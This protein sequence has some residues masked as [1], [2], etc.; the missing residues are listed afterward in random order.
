M[1]Q[2]GSPPSAAAATST[3]GHRILQTS[4]GQQIIVVNQPNAQSNAQVHI[5]AIT[6]SRG[7]SYKM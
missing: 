7:L 3:G 6:I 5:F 4:T 1:L 2:H